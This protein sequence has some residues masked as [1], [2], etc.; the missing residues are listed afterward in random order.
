[1]RDREEG[2]LARL[3]EYE[4]KLEARGYTLVCGVDE[5]G[6]G[7][8]A[9]P[10]VAAAVIL[11]AGARLEGLGDSKQLTPRQRERLAA[12]I[13]KEAVAWA[14]KAASVQEINAT[15]ILR[16][17]QLAML[18]A[19]AALS[20]GPEWVLVD[21]PHPLR[22][23][24][25]PQTP[26]V[27]GDATS[28]SIA[29]ASILAKVTRDQIMDELDTRYPVYGFRRHRGYPTPEHVAALLKYGPSPVHRTNFS[30][31]K[32][33]LMTTTRQQT[34]RRGE[35]AAVAYL[36]EHGYTI[37][38]RNYRRREGEL[39]L[40]A[41]DGSTLVFIE[42][43]ARRNTAFGLPQESV[44]GRKQARIRQLARCFLA[45]KGTRAAAYRFDVIAVSWG[46]EG[47]PR[48]EHIKNAF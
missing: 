3:W 28:A 38:C 9:G 11:P 4:R 27:K 10:V 42:V 17:A 5:A 30:P 33:L 35:E 1:M 21:G 25:I 13:K 44:I 39:D 47:K 22:A 45:E 12:R 34:G 46:P 14:V 32:E 20:V 26:L 43:K 36:Q 29:A 19:L 41:M 8:L 31:V 18:R 48:I 16:A 23:L 24:A 15:N 7:P 6:R 37:V 2:C 40:V